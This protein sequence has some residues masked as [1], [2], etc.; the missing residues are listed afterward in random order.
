MDIDELL[1]NASQMSDE[2]LSDTLKQI[3]KNRLCRPAAGRPKGTTR[4]RKKVVV[5][6]IMSEEEEAEL[7]GL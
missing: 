3:R 7:K 2:E 1:Q 6:I 5:P 4:E